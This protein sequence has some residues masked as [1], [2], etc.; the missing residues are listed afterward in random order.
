M[1]PRISIVADQDNWAF[2]NIGRQVQRSL[3]DDFEIDLLYRSDFPDELALLLAL[4]G[5][6]LVHFMWR[7]AFMHLLDG[8][9]EKQGRAIGHSTRQSIL[10]LLL[11]TSITTAIYDHLFLS[12]E[13]RHVWK[14]TF[15]H[16]D[17]YYVC[18][19]KLEDI[20][21]NI[22]G[23]PAPAAVLQDGVDLSLF[24]PSDLERFYSVVTRPL[25]IGWAGNSLW[26]SHSGRDPKGLHTLLRP[27]LGI[28]NSRG[29]DTFEVFADRAVQFR[30]LA[31]MPSYYKQV[32][33]YVCVSEA[34]GTPNPILEAM[35]CGLPIVTTDVGIA[36]EAF[37][38]LQSQFILP[39]RSVDAL[40]DAIARLR[41][42][43]ALMSELS[44][45]NMHSIKQWDWTSRAQ[46]FAPFFAA[47]I[48][49]KA[50]PSTRRQKFIGLNSPLYAE[51]SQ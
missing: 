27:A 48:A 20:Y 22:T 32:D 29:I 15:H 46:A 24:R 5:Y 44:M 36:R 37:G 50:D 33:I 2:A 11:N 40:V 35:A 4:E 34:E 28:L 14:D 18:S 23:Y 13:E 41:A 51:P 47:A 9:V 31:E 26:N 42:E 43:P 30:P 39:E 17:A 19:K 25:N 38:S 21:N 6:E 45:E 7:R 1:R 10:D 12:E 3:R 16:C 49:A 8:H